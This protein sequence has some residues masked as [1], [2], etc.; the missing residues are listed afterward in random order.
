MT[1]RE[2]LDTAAFCRLDAV[3]PFADHA[4][5]CVFAQVCVDTMANKNTETG[6]ITMAMQPPAVG[7]LCTSNPDLDRDLPG[8]TELRTAYGALVMDALAEALDRLGTSGSLAEPFVGQFADFIDA[9]IFAV[10]LN[11]P[12][13]AAAN[14]SPGATPAIPECL[15]SNCTLGP[16]S[17]DAHWTIAGTAVL[18]IRHDATGL[19]LDTK[20]NVSTADAPLVL[21]SCNGSPTQQWKK[22]AVNNQRYTLASNVSGLCL[23][24]QPGPGPGSVAVD[25]NTRLWLQACNGRDNQVFSNTDANVVGPN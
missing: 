6:R 18:T 13:K 3:D 23:T 2:H 9:P 21:W 4:G 5:N 24:I 19:C 20:N 22:Q 12:L 17:S 15:F 25:R 11:A 1:L 16:N 14:A 10:A 8:E 7:T